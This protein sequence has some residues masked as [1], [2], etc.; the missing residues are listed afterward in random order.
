[1]AFS[2]VLI[3]IVFA[4]IILLSCTSREKYKQ[5]LLSDDKTKIDI[6]CFELGELKD[7]SAVKPL[8]AK[9]LD[10][11]VSTNLRFKGMS[12]N[13]CRLGALKKISGVDIGRK[14]DQFGPDTAATLFYLDWA[15]KEGFLKSKDEVDI[16]YQA[17][18]NIDTS[19]YVVLK[20]G[21][22]KVFDN[23]KPTT[24]SVG[25][26]NQIEYLLL[27]AIDE[28]NKDKKHYAKIMPLSK[29]KIQLVPVINI[30]GGKE[31]W[32]NSFCEADGSR[33]RKELIFVEDGGNSYFQLKINLKTMKWY[34]MGINGYALA[35]NSP[36]SA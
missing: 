28:Y 1:M 13:Y 19:Q 5:D 33:W 9:I 29:Y 31:V 27:K 21:N 7:T 30:N 26:I 15:V 3:P 24:L 34:S 8:F 14:I 4:N 32:V 12:V 16:Y 10:P 18:S 20:Y 25:E 6:A 36:D 11:R 22:Y 2:R 35:V 17:K 23:A